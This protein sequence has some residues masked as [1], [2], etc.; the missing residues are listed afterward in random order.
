MDEE[1]R[2]VLIPRWPA[3]MHLDLLFRTSKGFAVQ[4]SD[5][6]IQ[7]L[8][9]QG[10]AALQL[11]LTVNDYVSAMSNLSREQAIAA[12]ETTQSQALAALNPSDRD[13]FSVA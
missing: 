4:I 5:A 6:K 8:R 12:V 1:R 11:Y 3:D 10:I 13:Q 2:I 9:D 7:A